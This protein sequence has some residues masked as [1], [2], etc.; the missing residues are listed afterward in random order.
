[1]SLTGETLIITESLI[2]T[3]LKSSISECILSL[4]QKRRV[5]DLFSLAVLADDS[6]HG[7]QCISYCFVQHQRSIAT[8]VFGQAFLCPAVCNNKYSSDRLPH[9][10]QIS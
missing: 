2:L 3:T 9:S 6:F 10:N 4:L 1:M 5:K 8:K 7:F